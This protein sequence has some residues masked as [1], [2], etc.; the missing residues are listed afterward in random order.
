MNDKWKNNERW[1]D[2]EEWKDNN[3][4]KRTN[5]AKS[6][7]CALN[8]INDD[9]DIIWLNGDV[10]FDNNVIK[11]VVD[12]DGACVAVNTKPVDSEEVKYNLNED[13][14]IKQ[15]SKIIKDGLGEAVGINKIMGTQLNL[16]KKTLDQCEEQDYFERGLEISIEKGMKIF[17]VDITQYF[18]IEVDNQGDLENVNSVINNNL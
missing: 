10:V 1:D 16:Y 3:N 13:G 6:L 14:T 2:N 18:C 17:P 4:Y 12:F 9:D 15:I 5:T 11:S 7:L 8:N